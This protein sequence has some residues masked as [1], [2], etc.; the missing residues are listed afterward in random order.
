MK[1]L[2]RVI[3]A[4]VKQWW[5]SQS[6]AFEVSMHNM[7]SNFFPQQPQL[8][9]YDLSYGQLDNIEEKTSSSGNSVFDWVILMAAPKSKV[10]HRRLSFDRCLL[11]TNNNALL[12]YIRFL[13]P[14]NAKSI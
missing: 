12:Y 1:G 14:A 10:S 11:N 3:S 9:G 8:V 2:L 7:L 5:R 6:S 13:H 4:P